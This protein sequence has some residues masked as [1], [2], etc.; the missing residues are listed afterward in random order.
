[1][2]EVAATI[3]D[4]CTDGYLV[5]RRAVAIDLVRSCVDVIE[6]ELRTR[7]V[8]PRDP[9]TWREPVVRSLRVPRGPRIRRRG[10]VA[11]TPGDVRRAARGGALFL[12][13]DVGDDDALT[14]LILGSHL[15]IPRVL[16]PFGERGLFFGDVIPR[17]HGSTF[18]RPR[19]RATGQAGDVF[20]CHP[21]LVHRA[22][23]PHRGAGPRMVAQ[24]A[25]A[26]REP[27]TLRAAVDVC[28]VERAIHRG[29]EPSA[30]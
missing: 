26:I 23:W 1:M 27:F 13:T 17:L 3:G 9:S 25:V 8:D 16:A 7:A 28:P 5:V 21:F 14:E 30:H 2:T 19:R 6:A 11:G 29:L 4:F 18:E 24:P 12:F 10:Y 22:T 15:D 20:L